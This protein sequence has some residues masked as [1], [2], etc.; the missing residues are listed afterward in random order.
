[1][2][3]FLL[4]QYRIDELMWLP[5]SLVRRSSWEE[6]PN[7]TWNVHT[8]MSLNFLISYSS[9]VPDWILAFFSINKYLTFWSQHTHLK[10][11]MKYLL[12]HLESLDPEIVCTTLWLLNLFHLWY[13]TLAREPW[14]N[15]CLKN[16]YNK[17]SHFA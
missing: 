16:K 6:L 2:I 7:L 5:K 17:I 3:L 4:I 9:S 14:S 13:L 15:F 11:R 1:M 10:L 8:I 12:I